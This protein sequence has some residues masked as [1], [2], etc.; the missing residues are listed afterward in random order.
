[1]H[2][3]L[4]L[5]SSIFL[6]AAMVAVFPTS[7]GAG[8]N[9]V[10]RI[11]AGNAHTCALTTGGALQCWG[12]N[13][14][15]QLGDNTNQTRTRPVAV[16]GLA[17]GMR[18]IAAGFYHSCAVGVDGAARCWG[19]N[20]FGQLGDGSA[21]TRLSPVTVARLSSGV[22]AITAGALHT[23]A[24]TEAGAVQCWGLNSSGQLGDNSTSQRATPAAVSGLSSAVAAVAA[25]GS[26]TCAL[27]TAG[28][29]A[30]WGSNAFGQLG[31]GSTTSRAAPVAIFGNGVAAIAAGGSHTCALTASGAVL[32]WGSNKVGQLGDTTITDRLVPTPVAGLGAAVTAIAAG[33]S[34]TCAL[35]TAGAVKCWG[36]NF[37]G[38]LGDNSTSV[39]LAP[40]AVSGLASGASLLAAGSAH[41]CSFAEEDGVRCWGNN[42][43]GQLGDTTTTQRQVPARVLANNLPD[44]PA[45]IVANAGNG[46]ASISFSIP[47]DNG[48]LA[49]TGYTVKSSP[50]GGVDLN[51]GSPSLTH[52]V[53]GLANDTAYTFTVTAANAAGS[54]LASKSSNSVTP[55]AFAQLA[56]NTAAVSLPPVFN[57]NAGTGPAFISQ[58][59]PLLSNYYG[60]DLA[61]L[62]QNNSGS[63]ELSG[64]G[65][66]TL[67]FLPL[68]FRSGDAR[69]DGLYLIDNAPLLAV[70]VGGTSLAMVP[71]VV[72][73]DQLAALFPGVKAVVNE[74]GVIAASLGGVTYVVQPDFAVRLDGARGNAQLA[75]ESAAALRFTDGSGNSQLLD[76]VLLEPGTVRNILQAMDPAA[77]LEV[78]VDGTAGI[79]VNGQ[80]YALQP[81]LTLGSIPP[82]RAGQAFWQDG[83]SHYQAMNS[84]RPGTVQGATLK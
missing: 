42:A 32:C 23:C 39:R 58:M 31:D 24:L 10:A 73:L 28:G 27:S 84:T 45:T 37:Y 30:C 65:S 19:G 78:R 14:S 66:G 35:T 16:T 59:L 33:E 7:H 20:Q 5:V 47:A 63:V 41:S 9:G 21:S 17:S 44:A 13:G 3:L 38:Q 61:Y 80:A 74:N 60:V 11:A 6:V 51:A 62:R 57:M 43:F 64:Y 50:P 67:A 25:G 48:G 79:V 1:M 52:V 22:K 82:E 8:L 46:Q 70:V 68:A 53:T 2:R 18:D 40:V 83:A 71:A 4:K 56:V 49:V 69:S 12:A 75:S 36:E 55:S 54:S 29:V 15:G 34:H 77:T 76:A 81:D 26:H 72:N